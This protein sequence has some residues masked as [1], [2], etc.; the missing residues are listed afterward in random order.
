MSSSSDEELYE[1][2]RRQVIRRPRNFQNRRLFNTVNP[3][4]FREKFRLPVD[5][6][7]RL[8]ELIGSRLEHRTRPNRTL[9]ARQQ[10]LVFLHF[11]GQI[12]SIT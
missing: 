9:T 8:L 4:E 11:L 7:V 3:R 6:F 1:L 12:P 2:L 5:A 10:L